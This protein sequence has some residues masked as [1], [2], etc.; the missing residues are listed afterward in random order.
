[1]CAGYC[2][3]P[4]IK[5]RHGLGFGPIVNWIDPTPVLLVFILP[6]LTYPISNENKSPTMFSI[7]FISVGFW[8]CLNNCT[9]M[10]FEEIPCKNSCTCFLMYFRNAL[11]DHLPIS[12]IKK[13]GALERYMTITAPEQMDF[14]PNSN[15]QI[16]SFVS[17]IVTTL[18]WPRLHISAGI[19]WIPVFSIPV[20]CFK[21]KSQFLFHHNLGK[22]AIGKLVCMVST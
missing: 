2:K 3:I 16:P 18:L 11:L 5:L 10:I 17:P 19:L 8:T 7:G 22:K 21:Q 13:I 6:L 4:N 1:M 20:A 15:R 9:L 14:V 12:M